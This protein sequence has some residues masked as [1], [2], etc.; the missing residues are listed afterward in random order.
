[1]TPFGAKLR[2]LRQARGVEQKAMAA[3]LGVSA[4]YLSALE[5]GRR[6]KPTWAMIQKIIGYFN[7]IWDE[8]E[9]LQRLAEI[10][11]PR[12]VVDTVNLA[13]EAT[14]LANRLAERIRHLSPEQIAAMQAV[15]DQPAKAASKQE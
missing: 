6:G 12:V 9:D 1:M 3:A 7:V 15:I 10:S 8:A 4:S 2:Q 11:D 13:P 5:H 14:A